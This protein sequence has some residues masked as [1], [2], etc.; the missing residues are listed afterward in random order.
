MDAIW[1]LSKSEFTI[2]L[3]AFFEL[4]MFLVLYTQVLASLLQ[5]QGAMMVVWV[6]IFQTF[7]TSAYS[8][9]QSGS[10]PPFGAIST[11]FHRSCIRIVPMALSQHHH[12]PSEHSSVCSTTKLTPKYYQFQ[13][14]RHSSVSIH[15]HQS[16]HPRGLHVSSQTA[17]F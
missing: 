7:Q 16:L 15:Q 17:S 11:N 13:S 8:W 3:L 9:Y 12:H 5:A 14:R 4:I 6:Y 2:L 10:A 1:P